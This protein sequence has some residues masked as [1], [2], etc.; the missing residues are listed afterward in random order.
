MFQ[1]WTEFLLMGKFKCFFD[2]W[3][4][5]TEMKLQLRV[6]IKCETKRNEI[7]EKKRNEINKNETKQN[8][9]ALY[10]YP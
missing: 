10:R 8:E 3:K 6:P 7:N 9:I 1:Y 4:G 5:C 2:S